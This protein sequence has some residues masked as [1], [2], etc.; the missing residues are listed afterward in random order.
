V[1]SSYVLSSSDLRETTQRLLHARGYRSVR[2]GPL[3][4][5]AIVVEHPS[6]ER[7]RLDTL[8]R[9]VDPGAARVKPAV[10]QIARR[11]PTMPQKEAEPKAVDPARWRSA[12]W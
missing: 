12:W 3:K 5:R 10:P 4:G 6:E 8:M 9:S 7:D 11:A 1:L 2:V